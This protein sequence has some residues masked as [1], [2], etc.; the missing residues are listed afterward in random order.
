MHLFEDDLDPVHSL[1]ANLNPVLLFKANYEEEHEVKVGLD[2]LHGV[3]KA[4]NQLELQH[5]IQISLNIQLC[6]F[7]LEM[8]PFFRASGRP[9]KILFIGWS[10]G[11]T[12][13][14]HVF[15]FM[16]F[17]CSGNALVFMVIVFE[18]RIVICI[19]EFGTVFSSLRSRCMDAHFIH[20]VIRSEVF[21]ILI[22]RLD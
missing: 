8:A 9:P 7:S 2:E 13:Y 17:F 12:V 11:K 1:Y 22:A 6:F 10:A 14:L 16:A 4:F 19:W 20:F 18:F 15:P 21:V 5:L 3:E